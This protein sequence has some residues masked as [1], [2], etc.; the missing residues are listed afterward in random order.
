MSQ[1][2]AERSRIKGKSLCPALS[3]HADT[4]KFALPSEAADTSLP[5]TPPI[6]HA[7]APMTTRAGWVCCLCSDNPEKAGSN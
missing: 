6:I 4:N 2:P 5:G 1:T 3:F 7:L